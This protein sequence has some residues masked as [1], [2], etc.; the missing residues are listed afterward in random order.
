MKENRAALHYNIIIYYSYSLVKNIKTMK[1]NTELAGSMSSYHLVYFV[2][3]NFFHYHFFTFNFH[4]DKK[5]H[6]AF[7]QATEDHNLRYQPL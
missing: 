6:I 1:K 4:L 2:N 3:F 7:N 5:N